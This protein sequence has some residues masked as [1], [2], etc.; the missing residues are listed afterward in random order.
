MEE[1]L[2]EGRA[3]NT[4]GMSGRLSMVGTGDQGCKA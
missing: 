3:G 4:A 2:E 1:D